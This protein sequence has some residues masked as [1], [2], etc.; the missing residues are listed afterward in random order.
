MA[1]LDLAGRQAI[2]LTINPGDEAFIATV[3]IGFRDSPGADG[4]KIE[5]LARYQGIT[6]TS[7]V[8]AGQPGEIVTVSLQA[9]AIDE[10]VV[11]GADNAALVDL[12][13]QPVFFL[14]SG[15][16]K[17]VGGTAQ[18][19][20]LPV[21]AP[22]YPCPTAP[23]SF[24]A[25]ETLALS[26]VRYGPPAAWAG[27]PFADL[28]DRLQ[29]LVTGGPPPGGA[30]MADRFESIVGSPPPPPEAGG[31][32][33]APTQRP[34]ELVLLASLNAAVA[35]ILGLAWLDATAQPG[36]RYDYILLADHDGSL[37]SVGG[38]L[39][40]LTSAT[41][42]FSVIDGF[43]LLNVAV[44]PASPLDPPAAGQAVALPGSTIAPDG[45]GPVIDGTN[46]TGLTWDRQQVGD[47]LAA[48]API[49]YHVWRAALGNDETPGTAADGDFALITASGPLPV[50]RAVLNPPSVP[51]Q[52]GDWPPFALQYVDR[53][54]PDGWYGYRVSA[55]DIFG[56]H[57]GNSPSAAWHQWAPPPI[58]RPWYYRDPPGDQVLDP[59]AIRLLDKLA[60][61]PPP[62]VEATAL[63][64]D[65]PA[66]LADA[67]WQSWRA[68][69][70]AAER[71]NVVGLRVRWRWGTAQQRQAPDTR[72]F[73]VYVEPALANT[74]RGRVT[75]VTA[76]SATESLVA[77]D[78]ASTQ[79]SDAFA[80]TTIRV[81]G[82]G[83]AVVGSDAASPLR[84]RVRNIGP[85]DDV[86]PAPRERI[87][88]SIPAWHAL[89]TDLS[90]ATAWAT[91]M[92]VCGF[93][94]HVTV[95]GDE[96]TY[97]LLLPLA[98]LAGPGRP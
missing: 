30:A 75:G 88:L 15:G 91:R 64:P 31:V 58:P 80:G 70:S 44:G 29:A 20:C 42:D 12:C 72:E 59:G 62:A 8:A 23:A 68:S 77:T 34:L 69:L 56:R 92:A 47:V 10:V 60:P 90:D 5:L 17:P 37:R 1:E 84:L 16:W 6:V 66:V 14:V 79:G 54:L 67:A 63:A 26:R 49:L 35:E 40:F 94:E 98:G 4:G 51:S 96:R 85:A 41:P 50:A 13:I 48:G 74:L 61:P 36:V 57:S 18:P 89:Y 45:G 32:I 78:I 82:S 27:A 11:P 52:P 9:A 46:N 95:S 73:R 33:I 24:A 28:H 81:A 97:E 55:I 25:A 43:L 76:A 22:G 2:T 21:A 19:I 86:A 83:F 53:A 71:D 38:A 7:G 3:K 39:D 65:D 87:S 93:D